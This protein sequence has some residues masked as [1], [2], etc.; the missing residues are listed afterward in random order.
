MGF[1]ST[2]KGWFNML[3]KSKV[4]EEFEVGSI[5]SAPVVRMSEYCSRIYQGEPDWIDEDEHIKTINFAKV[6]CSE[7]ARL[8]TLAIKVQI[9]GS[10]RA[11]WLQKQIDKEY[12]NIREWVEYADAFGTVILKPTLNGIDLFTPDK[13]MVTDAKDGDITGV[14]FIHSSASGDKYYT[15]L[16][17]HRFLENGDY[18][19]SNRCY[20]GDSK[21]D[22]KNQVD[23]ENTPWNG[24]LEEVVIQNIERPLY[25]VLKTPNANNVEIGSPVSLAVFADAIEELKD[26]DIAYSRNAKEISDSKRTVLLDSD[27][28]IPEGSK[29]RT[30]MGESAKA[31]RKAMGLPD[32]VRNVYGDGEKT[33]YEEINP[34]L[35]TDKRIKGINFLLSVIGF[36]CGYSNGYFV[37]DE[38]TGMITAT[39]VESDDRRTIQ[40]IK[41]CRDKL[42]L[43]L[44]QLI[45]A[46]NA[47]ADLYNLAPLGVYEIVYDFGDITYNR[48]EDRA[49]WY[50]YASSNR[51]PFW[52]YLVKF[53]GLTE[54]DA[55]AL[56]KES[57]PKMTQ[58]FGG[59]E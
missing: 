8:T 53:E 36:K 9:E 29:V 52:Y 18:A 45:Y 17:Y 14:V 41:D 58:L 32:Y 31:I 7:T 2:I 33:F 25:G 34:T 42:E 55:K 43:C 37:F 23:I 54:E 59:V 47:F 40:L 30:M 12:Y 16:E 28:I 38:K 3:F 39:Q 19:V 51:V 46:L 56:V 11:E 20:E 49:R 1:I 5:I 27:R 15:L 44:T 4:K 50:S 35:N 6:I 24:L 48:E 57:E 22:M 26:L 13:F 10:A 21:N